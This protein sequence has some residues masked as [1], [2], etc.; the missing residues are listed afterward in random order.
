MLP[1][2]S[3]VWTPN[4]RIR[5]QALEIINIYLLWRS[6][7]MRGK[8]RF[9][10]DIIKSILQKQGKESNKYRILRTACKWTCYEGQ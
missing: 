5:R 8:S 9:A 10:S 4:T 1:G 2:D 3:A 6:F 7:V